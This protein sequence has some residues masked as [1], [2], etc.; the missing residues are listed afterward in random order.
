MG[1]FGG[2]H[3]W[4]ST[5][6]CYTIEHFGLFSIS[7]LVKGIISRFWTHFGRP[8]GTKIGGLGLQGATCPFLC[9]FLGC[10]LCSHFKHRNKVE[11][12]CGS[13]IRVGLNSVVFGLFGG[14][15]NPFNSLKTWKEIKINKLTRIHYL[16]KKATS[17]AKTL[18]SL[19]AP[20]GPA[21]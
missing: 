21:D 3:G 18:H 1:K 5:V 15:Q 13:K 7:C 20:K 12:T 10:S 16:E 9:C 4:L 19:V 17:G 6:P 14:V 2:G 11:N 8:G